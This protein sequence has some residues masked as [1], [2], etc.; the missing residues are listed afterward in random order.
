MHGLEL[1]NQLQLLKRQSNAYTGAPMLVKS[2]YGVSQGLPSP[3]EDKEMVK[4]QCWESSYIADVLNELGFKRY[5]DPDLLITTWYSSDSPLGPWVFDNLE[6]KYYDGINKC[7]HER[8]LLFDRIN[9]A[10]AEISESYMDRCPWVRSTR[11]R[12][13]MKW[14]K[15]EVRVELRKMLAVQE[16][17]ANYD[18]SGGKLLDKEMNW[19]N[20]RDTINTIGREIET[21]LINELLTEFV[22]TM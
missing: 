22:A 20:S 3:V 4:S 12:F 11:S 1:Q 17:E 8:R 15:R 5:N 2:D 9:S 21:L 14:Q 10:L 18:I 6:N 19:L 7:K 13:H 16:N